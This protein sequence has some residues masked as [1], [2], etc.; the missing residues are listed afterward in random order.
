M[1]WWRRRRRPRRCWI[2]WAAR[3]RKSCATR[4]KS[5]EA[6]RWSRCSCWPCLPRPDFQRTRHLRHRRQARRHHAGLRQAAICAAAWRTSSG[7][8]R[9]Q[10]LQHGGRRRARLGR[11]RRDRPA[12]GRLSG[13]DSA[14]HCI[15]RVPASSTSASGRMAALWL[16]AARPFN[17]PG[18]SEP[19]W[20]RIETGLAKPGHDQAVHL[21]ARREA[22]PAPR[23][24]PFGRDRLGR[25]HEAGNSA[26]ISSSRQGVTATAVRASGPAT[27]A[28][29]SVPPVAATSPRPNPPLPVSRP[30]Q[31][32][33]APRPPAQAAAGG[34]RRRPTRPPSPRP[35]CAG[36]GRRTMSTIVAGGQQLRPFS[37]S[38]WPLPS[39]RPAGRAAPVERMRA[40]SS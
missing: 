30:R 22:G 8:E 27:M 34:C 18:S 11:A 21:R 4:S 10:R 12:I 14:R 35:R 3:S 39:A 6:W 24:Q 13:G 29:S 5:I 40:S 32:R 7:G 17:A 26:T 33:A 31:A 15:V 36:G 9:R 37:T 2:R 38:A 16:A 1:V 19:E 25:F 23:R 28:T 20:P